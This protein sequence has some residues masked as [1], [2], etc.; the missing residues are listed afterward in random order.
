MNHGGF[1]IEPFSS[2]VYGYRR[3]PQTQAEIC[4]NMG[5][6]CGLRAVTAREKYPGFIYWEHNLVKFELR[7]RKTLWTFDNAICHPFC[8]GLN[9]LTHCGLVT[10]YCNIGLGQHRFWILEDID[11][12]NRTMLYLFSSGFGQ[13]PQIRQLEC[14]VR[15][16]AGSGHAHQMELDGCIWCVRTLRSNIR[17]SRCTEI[18]CCSTTASRW[19]GKEVVIFKWSHSIWLHLT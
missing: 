17:T 14:D 1:N 12:Y 8:L 4:R 19:R 15:S 7:Y 5:I 6:C 11:C 3:R 2:D 10:P 18:C 13:I 9:V 16:Q